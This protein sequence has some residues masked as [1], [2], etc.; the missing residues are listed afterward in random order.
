M[1]KSAR[2]PVSVLIPAYNAEATISQTLESVVSQTM[3]PQEILVLDD[4]STDRTCDI[5]ANF[6]PDVRLIR[7]ENT[8]VAEA[9]NRLLCMAQNDLVAFLD[10]D[11]CLYPR[12][13][14][15]QVNARD[16]YPDAVAYYTKFQSV[17]AHQELRIA[18]DFGIT[19]QSCLVDPQE[20][21]LKYNLA[22][23]FILPSFTILSKSILL[24]ISEKPF[25]ANLY[26]SDDLYLWYRLALLGP[27]VA[28][29]DCLGSYRL[30][31]KS[32]SSDRVFMYRERL[33]AMKAIKAVYD[34]IA[35]TELRKIADDFLANTFRQYG[36]H[37]MGA[38][39]PAEA[40]D[41]LKLGL[42]ASFRMKT[43][44]VLAA[45]YLPTWAQPKWPAAKRE[46]AVDPCQP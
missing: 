7:Q 15:V 42:K 31:E 36:K 45:T 6:S 1:F 10:H 33:K 28:S 46:T 8:G 24:E 23:G 2:T 21:L 4:G 12:Y 27:F 34:E 41:V 25:P 35:P 26:G 29:R 9:R 30:V 43:A 13:F 40:Q 19:G 20:F 38:G 14:E 32:L 16:Q 44:A 3:P 17:P 22:S 37:L 18:D 5:V 11:D 39:N